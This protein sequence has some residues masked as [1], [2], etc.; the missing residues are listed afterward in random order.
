[1]SARNKTYQVVSKNPVMV[2]FPNGNAV[3]FHSGS[4]FEANSLNDH[5]VRLLRVNAIRE[6][7]AREIPNKAVNPAGRQ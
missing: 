6:V 5:I 1:M 4:T 3:S 2:E 7:T